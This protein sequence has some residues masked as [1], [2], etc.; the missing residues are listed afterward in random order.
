MESQTKLRVETIEHEMNME[1]S[2]HLEA[3]AV[4]EAKAKECDEANAKSV[5]MI[6]EKRAMIEAKREELAK[7]WAVSFLCTVFADSLILGSNEKLFAHV[8]Y[9]RLSE[10][11]RCSYSRRSGSSTGA[12]LGS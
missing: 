7:I 2:R 5:E 1:M 12:K 11:Q 8:S 6:D 10:M 9:D 4:L 3:V